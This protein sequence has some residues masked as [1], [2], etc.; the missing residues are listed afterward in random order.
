M[1]QLV[2]HVQNHVKIVQDQQLLAQ[3]ALTLEI[4]QHLIVIVHRHLNIWIQQQ[5]CV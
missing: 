3:V 1:V 2:L 5:K 4:K